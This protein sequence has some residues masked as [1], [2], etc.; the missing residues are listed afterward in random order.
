MVGSFGPAVCGLL[1]IFAL[2]WLGSRVP[3]AVNWMGL[4]SSLVLGSSLGF[5]VFSKSS[6]L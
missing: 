5:I 2:L 1:S 3:N 4:C 6:E